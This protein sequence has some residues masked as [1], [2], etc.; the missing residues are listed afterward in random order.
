MPLPLIA[1]AAIA[2]GSQVAGSQA[3][4][5]ANKK[6]EKARQAALNSELDLREEIYSDQKTRNQP[7]LDFG[8]GGV[9]SLRDGYDFRQT[10]EY[11]YRQEMGNQALDSVGGFDQGVLQY[12]QGEM[13][14]GLDT[15]EQD[16]EYGRIIDRIKIGQGQSSSAGQQAQQYGSALAN[17]QQQSANSNALT[18][19]YNTNANQDMWQRGLS[20]A[21]S[22]PSYI[23]QRNYLQGLNQPQMSNAPGYSNTPS[24]LM[25][26]TG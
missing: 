2:I 3:Q 8:Y 11:Q 9:N 16:S 5:S 17:I 4:K 20:Q 22:V 14:R 21:S 26:P 1:G 23:Q 7:Y 6:A 24:Y 19:M 12:A 25:R 15:Q 10:P 13:G 18:S